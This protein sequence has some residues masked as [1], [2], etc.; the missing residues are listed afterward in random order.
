MSNKVILLIMDGWGLGKES[1]ES[2]IYKANTFYDKAIKVF[3]TQTIC[4]WK[5]CRLT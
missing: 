5:R 1:D 4:F 2:A 3:Q